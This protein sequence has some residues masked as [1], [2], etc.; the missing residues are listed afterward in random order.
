MTKPRVPGSRETGIDLPCGESVAV[1]TLDM[2][3]R[4]FE[5]S[6]GARHAVVMDVHPLSRFVPESL[7]SVLET[8]IEPT[9]GGTFDTRHLM[10]VV[11]EE[12]PEEVVGEDV[13]EDTDVGYAWVWVAEFDSR[14]LHEVV[15][16]LVVELMDHAVSHAENDA[17]R[18]E[19]ESQLQEFD[20][21]AFVDA[22]RRERD[23]ER[24]T[25]T[26]V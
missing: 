10:G 8:A 9:D 1:S 20:V 6:C 24:G 14:R 16:E 17:A 13:S 25:D 7:V 26:P 18:H 15:V 2:G 5:C 19:F 22:Y 11:L 12:F 21:E 3:L 4:E 23:F